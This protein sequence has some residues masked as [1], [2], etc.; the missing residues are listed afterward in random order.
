MGLAGEVQE[1]LR[2]GDA[3]DEAWRS[4]SPNDFGPTGQAGVRRYAQS[5][6]FDI[7]AFL[8]ANLGDLTGDQEQRLRNLSDHLAV[9][10]EGQ[11]DASKKS[12]AGAGWEGFKS[13]LADNPITHAVKSG[14]QTYIDTIKELPDLLKYLAVAATVL[15]AFL[16]V[17]EIKR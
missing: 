14:I 17:R 15:G 1:L 4:A 11:L 16:L 3:A 7:S 13:S 2:R 12:V 10:V 9:L 8:D 6:R 5:L